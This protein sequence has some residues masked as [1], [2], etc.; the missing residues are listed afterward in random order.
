MGSDLQMNDTEPTSLFT[1]A[2]V[3]MLLR[4]NRNSW[5]FS[6]RILLFFNHSSHPKPSLGGAADERA[7]APPDTALFGSILATWAAGGAADKASAQLRVCRGSP[8]PSRAGGCME[9][10][11][12]CIFCN[13]SKLFFS[14]TESCS[15]VQLNFLRRQLKRDHPSAVV[16]STDD[17]FIDNGVYVFEPEFLEDAHK[18]NQKRARKAMKNGKSPVIIDNTNIQ[19]WEM[20]PYVMMARENRYEVV[21]QEPDTPWKFNVRE[22][23]RRNIH[24]VPQEKIQRMKDQY[25]R[26]VTFHSVLQSEKPSR[27]ERSPSGP[28]AAYGMGAHSSPPPTSNRRPHVAPTNITPFH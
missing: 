28:N 12:L 17:F 15:T 19:A 16:L 22:L 14:A 9:L 23:T 4:S 1:E 26:S 27:D 24:R 8:G 6:R 7:P 13:S 11:I 21:F 5:I 20:K 3:A 2:A 18:W 25:E 10:K